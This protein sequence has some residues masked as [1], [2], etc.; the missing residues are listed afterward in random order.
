LVIQTNK[1]NLTQNKPN[2]NPIQTQFDE[3]PKMM[4]SIYIQRIMKKIAAMGQKK[5]TQFKA[6]NQSSLITNHLEGKPNSNP[7]AKYRPGG[8]V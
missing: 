3:R 5:Q 1:P 6:N 8:S 7:I 2:S 4:Q